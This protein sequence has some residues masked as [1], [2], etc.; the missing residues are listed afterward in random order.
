MPRSFACR[1]RRLVR[2]GLPAVAVLA[3]AL[4]GC[5]EPA[6]SAGPAPARPAPSAP[7]VPPAPTSTA[8]PTTGS[9]GSDGL[10]VRYLSADGRIATVSVEDFPRR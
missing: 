9:A 10:T 6:A 7:S 3:L 8:L 4:G 2:L 5:G 1:P